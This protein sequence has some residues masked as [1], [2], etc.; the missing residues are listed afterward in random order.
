MLKDFRTYR[1]LYNLG[2]RQL[3]KTYNGQKNYQNQINKM[4]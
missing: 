2:E 1:F 4:K 3:N